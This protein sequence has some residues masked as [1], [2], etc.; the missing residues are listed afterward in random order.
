MIMLYPMLLPIAFV[1]LNNNVLVTTIQQSAS[2]SIVGGAFLFALAF[3]LIPLMGKP[4]EVTNGGMIRTYIVNKKRMIWVDNIYK[5]KG[6]RRSFAYI[7][8]KE[9]CTNPYDLFVWSR[10]THVWVAEFMTFEKAKEA[11]ENELGKAVE[12]F[13]SDED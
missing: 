9:C 2:M 12:P 5:M 8:M 13:I 4:R 1:F 10:G 6:G 11:A 3:A 7:E